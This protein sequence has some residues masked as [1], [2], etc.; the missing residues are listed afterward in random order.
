MLEHFRRQT[1]FVRT[2][3]AEV[4][5]P[6]DS[7][8]DA[9][10]GTGE[11]TCFLAETV[12][13]TGR[14]YGFDIQ[15]AALTMARDK[16]A[17]RQWTGPVHWYH[18]GH[19]T[20]GTVPEIVQDSRIRA[21]MFNLGYFPGGDPAVVT[22]WETT[23]TALSAAAKVLAEGVARWVRALDHRFEAYRFSVENHQG[24]PVA[25]VIRKKG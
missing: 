23:L 12:G 13:A 22:R 17:E 7:A 11:D 21:A 16:L 10:V 3:V 14:V 4:L 20:L 5:T 15:K 9:T 6:G 1:D 18:Q 2:C 8:L 24:A 19:E 25:Y